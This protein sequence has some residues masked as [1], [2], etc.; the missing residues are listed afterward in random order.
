MLS[1]SRMLLAKTHLTDPTA[2]MHQTSSQRGY[3]FPS[4]YTGR[5]ERIAASKNSEKEL[6]TGPQYSGFGHASW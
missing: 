5:R 4:Q 3:F 1:N 2:S 6:A